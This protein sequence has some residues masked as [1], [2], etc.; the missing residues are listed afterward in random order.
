MTD[1][2]QDYD[3][4]N[5]RALLVASFTVKDLRR[6]C[7]DRPA[8]QPVVAR[9]SPD[10]GVTDMVDE[11]IDYC[12]THLLWDELLTELARER[13]KQYARAQP[14][15]GAAAPP[16]VPRPAR[17][18][19][20]V[21]PRG[22]AWYWRAAA[23]AGVLLAVALIVWWLVREDG[24]PAGGTETAVAQVPTT[25]PAATTESPV[26][27]SPLPSVTP[28]PSP[29]LSPTPLPDPYN[30]PWLTL[31]GPAGPLGAPVADPV[32]RRYSVQEFEHGT[33]FWRDNRF[34]T[35]NWIYVVYWGSADNKSAGSSWTRYADTW[36]AGDPALS[37]V[38]AA[39]EPVGPK[40]GF[41]RLWCFRMEVRNGLGS[42]LAE[43][44]NVK[45]GW[46]DFAQGVMLHDKLNGRVL[47]LF[48]DGHWRAFPD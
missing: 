33:M 38:Q 7:E 28:M 26:P 20:A 25:P 30:R 1:D 9:F 35:D 19:E 22:I 44:E 45:G 40:A 39:P 10:H 11:V 36:Q 13:W 41:G 15:L 18:M 17:W 4:G 2:R 43:E 34:E 3:I 8:F 16:P 24:S 12:R 27:A 47:V 5:I 37:C 48:E 6:F 29:M 31:G 21:G 23:L 46:L 14:D 42:A 32:T